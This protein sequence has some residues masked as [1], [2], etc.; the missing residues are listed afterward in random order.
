MGIKVKISLSSL[1]GYP[2]NVKKN[3]SLD[4]KREMADVIAE[5]ILSGKSPVAG[6][7]FEKYS[8][9]Y[10][11]KKGRS[12]PVDLLVTGKMLNSLEV[13]QNRAGSVRIFFR[14]AI[15]V[16]H[17]KKG[18]VIRRLLP[19]TGEDFAAPIR[20]KIISILKKAVRKTG[21]KR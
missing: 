9:G 18:R 4:L 6:K 2:K 16:F 1:K 14:S 12:A 10:A 5:R 3:F 15:A 17:D 21:R 19:R 20:R 7:K 8:E 11:K 13:R